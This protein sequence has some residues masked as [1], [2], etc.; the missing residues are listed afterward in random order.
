VTKITFYEQVGIIIPG[1][2]FLFGLLLY[3]PSLR[4]LLVSGGFTVGELGIFLLL[5]YAAGNLVAACANLAETL[6]WP[7]GG[8][9]PTN[10]VTK[11]E[12]TLISGQQRELLEKR[13]SSRLG[14][15]V[16]DIRGIN[17]QVWWPISRQLYSEVVRHGKPERIDIFNGNYGLNRGL[18]A[19]CFLLACVSAL[20]QR[21]W[22]CTFL[23]F[24]TA[25][26][27]Y[28]AYRFAIHYGREL[29]LEFLVLGDT[30]TA[31]STPEQ[32]VTTTES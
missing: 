20:E 25:I 7:L 22:P 17:S 27:G 8:G 24:A 23:A 26:Y 2:L 13:M 9:M 6:L 5:S 21:W 12:T 3:F 11:S 32:K 31:N 4:E 28:R 15:K 30:T 29:Y 16:N 14:I 10:W 18:A 19:A 1:A